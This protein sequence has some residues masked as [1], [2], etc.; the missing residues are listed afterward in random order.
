MASQWVRWHSTTPI[1]ELST[2]NGSSWIVLPLDGSILNQGP[3]AT[4]RLGSGTAN[5]T[6]FLRGDNTWQVIS[7]RLTGEIIMWPTTVAPSGWQLCDGS[8]LDRTTFAA[9]F[10]VIGTT[11]GSV[12]G[13]HFT[14]PDFRQKFP[15]GVAAAGTGNAIGATGGSIDHT[16]TSAAHT[17]TYT[18]VPNHVHTITD[19]GHTHNLLQPTATG[20]ALNASTFQTN[21]STR[22]FG[23]GFLDTQTTGITGTNN[24]TGG[25]ATGTTASTTPGNTGSNNPPFLAINFIIKT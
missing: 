3:V 23:S 20:G 25:V 22:A 6:T 24:P 14:V 7:S 4:A 15:L 9:L 21:A 11:Y 10:A 18:Q 5:N 1:Y 12:D 13:T 16:H 19:P 8:S 17:H 2:D